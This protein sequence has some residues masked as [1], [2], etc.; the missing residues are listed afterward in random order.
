[1]GGFTSSNSGQYFT[2]ARLTTSGTLDTTFGVN[3]VG[4]AGTMYIN[5]SISGAGSPY[6]YCTAVGLLPDGKIVM[7]GYT[8]NTSYYF[9]IAQLINPMS[10]QTYQTTYAAVGAGLYV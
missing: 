2:A 5:G 10:L 1:M 9:A 8:T 4:P 6:D 3:P 7:G